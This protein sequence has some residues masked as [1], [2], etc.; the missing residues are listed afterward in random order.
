MKKKGEV[1]Q[2]FMFLLAA[3]IIVSILIFGFKQ[4]GKLMTGMQEAEMNIL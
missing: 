1:N 2:A 3:I 4:V